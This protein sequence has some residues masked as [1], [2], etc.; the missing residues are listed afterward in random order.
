MAFFSLVTENEPDQELGEL[1]SKSSSKSA[2]EYDYSEVDAKKS[3]KKDEAEDFSENDANEDESDEEEE[4]EDAKVKDVK[5]K[6]DRMAQVKNGIN[7]TL[8]AGTAHHDQ[9]IHFNMKRIHNHL[10]IFLLTWPKNCMNLI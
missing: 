9:H 1:F 5:L 6:T 4:K 2:P 10:H 8:S 7:A 3:K